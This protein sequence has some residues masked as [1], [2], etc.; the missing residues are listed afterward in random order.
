D[1]EWPNF[2]F[3]KLLKNEEFSTRFFNEFADHLNSTFSPERVTHTINEMKSNIDPEI[4]NHINRW[5]MPE[6]Y[7]EWEE[8]V[9]VMI[10][11]AEERPDTVRQHII[12]HFNLNG[13]AN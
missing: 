8:N 12:E 4:R 1:E 6:T 5:K 2:L 9:Q 10:D 13:T 11:F 3:R 7:E